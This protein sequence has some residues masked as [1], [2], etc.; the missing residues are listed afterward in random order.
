MIWLQHLPLILI[1]SVSCILIVSI[2][3]EDL[4]N[5]TE[6]SIGT[7]LTTSVI[8]INSTELVD[9]SFDEDEEST[10]QLD[11]YFNDTIIHSTST[12]TSTTPSPDQ[13]NPLEGTIEYIDYLWSKLLKCGYDTCF[14]CFKQECTWC[15]SKAEN[16]MRLAGET[17]WPML[18]STLKR[19]QLPVDFDPPTPIKAKVQIVKVNETSSTTIKSTNS[20]TEMVEITTTIK[21]NDLI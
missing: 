16:C 10:D 2:N 5:S 4:V 14:N 12:S 11:N 20:S 1:I 19:E 15:T 18:L 7:V 8:Q 17:I 6:P 9:G 3:S 21:P 13:E